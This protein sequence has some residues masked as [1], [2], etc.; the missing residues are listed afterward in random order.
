MYYFPA[1]VQGDFA[2][3]EQRVIEA[4]NNSSLHYA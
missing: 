1:P 2:E 3:V 4:L